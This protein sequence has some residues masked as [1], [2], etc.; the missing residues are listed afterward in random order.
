MSEQDKV[1]NLEILKRMADT[2][3]Q[4]MKFAPLENVQTARVTRKGTLITIG[5]PGNVVVQILNDEFVGGL[6]L[7][8]RKRFTEVKAEMEAE[9]GITKQV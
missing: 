8:E 6:F 5:W 9:R 7:V 4:A 3:D 2:N 1:T